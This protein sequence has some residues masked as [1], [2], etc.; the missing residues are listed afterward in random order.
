MLNN[1]QTGLSMVE[2]LIALAISSFLILGIT[3]L[4]IDSKRSNY[5][6]AGQM[7]NNENTRFVVMMLDAELHKAGYRRRPDQDYTNVFP[8]G[9]GFDEGSAVRVVD[10][11]TFEIRYQPHSSKDISCS[12]DTQT[13][14]NIDKGYETGSISLETVRIGF[15]DKSIKCADNEIIS[16]VHAA[17]FLYAVAINPNNAASGFKYVKHNEVGNQ[18]IKGIRYRLLLNSTMGNLSDSV[19]SAAVDAFYAEGDESRPTA[20]AVYQT[21]TKNVQL[22]NLETW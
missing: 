10:E 2:L 18:K 6:Q 5:F 3:Q 1:K 12:G 19:D 4:Y 8:G 16:N 21:V 9:N 11:N 14:G 22:R 7:E 13:S 15:S 17:E 20:K